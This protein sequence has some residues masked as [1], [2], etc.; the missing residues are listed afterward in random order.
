MTNVHLYEAALREAGLD[1]YLVGGRAFFA[2]ARGYDLLNLLRAAQENPPDRVG[3]AGT[4]RSPFCCVSDEGLFVLSR[5][6][7]GLWAGLLDERGDAGQPPDQREPVPRARRLLQ[8]WRALKDRVPI[9]RLLGQVFAD[10]GYDAATQFEF[11]AE[12]KL[13]N[14]WKLLDLARKF[15]R[16]GLFGL[17]EFIARLGDLVRHQPREEQAATQPEN[18]DVVRLMTIHQA[19]GLEFPIVLIPDVS[20][21]SGNSAEPAVRSGIGGSAAW[22][23]PPPAEE[24]APAFA[25]F[26]WRLW[27]ARNEL[28]DWQEDLRTLYVACTRACDYLILSASLNE[29]ALQ[30]NAWMRTLLTD[31]FDPSNGECVSHP[32][33]MK[34]NGRGCAFVEPRIFLCRGLEWYSL[35]KGKCLSSC[36]RSVPTRV[37]GMSLRLDVLAGSKVRLPDW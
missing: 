20:A 24:E 23:K 29:S 21:K 4:L 11:L 7:Q 17:A 30:E 25:D 10:S 3:L 37:E 26:A 28:E 15:D 32:I 6:S 33:S 31:H 19:K 12:R 13:A 22:W 9:A 14:L 18:A 35:R 36:R 1:Y 16:S 5:H 8:Q 34:R 2:G 27:H